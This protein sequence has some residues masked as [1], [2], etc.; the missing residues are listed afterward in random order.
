MSSIPLLSPARFAPPFAMSFA[1]PVGDIDV[2]SATNP[3]PVASAPLAAA[4]AL[5]G[6]IA[7]TGVRGPF[8][9][10]LGRSV[11]LSLAGTWVG[12]VRLLRS[13]DGGTTKLPLTAM[14][15]TY[16]S[17]TANICEPVW[18]EGEVGATLYLD[19]TLTSGSLTYRMGQ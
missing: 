15:Q 7:A 1:N 5:A 4:T 10:V 12:T 19:V 2:V 18:E 17:Y 11:M 6:S 8:Q 9:P 3:I 13:V 16:G 14:G